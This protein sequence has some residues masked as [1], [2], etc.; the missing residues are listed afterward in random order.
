MRLLLDAMTAAGTLERFVPFDVSE[1]TLSEAPR[2]LRRRVPRADGAR[3]WW[4]T[5]TST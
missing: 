3:A 2:P 4:A 1:A 5:S